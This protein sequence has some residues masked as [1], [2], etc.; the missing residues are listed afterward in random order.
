M[1]LYEVI[2]KNKKM[3]SENFISEITLTRPVDNMSRITSKFHEKRGNRTHGGLD[4]ACPVGTDIKSIADGEVIAAGA[5]DSRCGDGVTVKHAD[6]FQSSYCHLS[7]IKVNKGE[8]VKQG[9]VIALSGGA[10]GAPGSGNSHGPHLHLTL[11]KNGE[12]VDPE[13]FIDKSILPPSVDGENSSDNGND[14]SEPKK[15]DGNKK[16]DE[17]SKP[18]DAALFSLAGDVAKKMFNMNENFGKNIQSSYGTISIPGSSNPKIKSPID[19]IVKSKF[20]SGCVNQILIESDSQPKF[21]LQ[22]CGVTKKKVNNG[23][24]VVVGQ[25]IGEMSNKDTVEVILMDSSFNRKQLDNSSNLNFKTGK[26][27]E[28][29]KG[30]EQTYWDAGLAGLVGLPKLMFGNVY[31]KETGKLKTRKWSNKPS[32]EP[33]DP[34]ILNAIK[35]P[36]KKKEQQEEEEKKIRENINRIKGL[37]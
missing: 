17:K 11:K 10:S 15:E 30:G 37:L 7:K 28:I 5:L 12:R 18:W 9:Q 4:I 19:G 24:K 33:V 32:S 34:W 6:G 3:F 13:L 14:L 27:S 21:Y 29:K 22:Y 2:E 1:N 23:D 20:I 16:E 25:V 8:T 35:K 36:F 26:N 31:D